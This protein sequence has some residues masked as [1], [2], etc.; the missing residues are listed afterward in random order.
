[1]T[2]VIEFHTDDDVLPDN[3]KE[4]FLNT[5][6]RARHWHHA[7]NNVTLYIHKR[8]NTGWLEYGID[9]KKP[10]GNRVIFIGAIQRGVGQS[11]EFHS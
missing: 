7:D 5:L 11:S 9:V 8:S 2:F 10:N 4:H 6:H 1:M 3:D